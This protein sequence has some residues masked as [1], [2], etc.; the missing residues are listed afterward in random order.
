M[1]DE[2]IVALDDSCQI[3]STSYKSM[4][5]WLELVSSELTISVSME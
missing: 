2:D 5:E 4:K 3:E 1:Y